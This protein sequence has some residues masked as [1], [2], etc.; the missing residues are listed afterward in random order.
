MHRRLLIILSCIVIMMTMT[1]TIDTGDGDTSS[2]I[3]TSSLPSSGVSASLLVHVP[4]GSITKE[5]L[6]SFSLA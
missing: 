2:P 3:P 6:H 4:Q 5:G 1:M